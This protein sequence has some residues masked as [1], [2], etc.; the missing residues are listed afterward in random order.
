MDN[1]ELEQIGVLCHLIGVVLIL[2]KEPKKPQITHHKNTRPNK[3][4]QLGIIRR[5]GKGLGH[6][7]RRFW[8]WLY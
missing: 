3:P 7:I 6:N 1:D 8:N 2:Q 4:E 5:T